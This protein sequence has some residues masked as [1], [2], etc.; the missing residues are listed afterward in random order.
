MADN[1]NMTTSTF[2][3]RAAKA[4]FSGTM[5]LALLAGC[6]PQGQLAGNQILYTAAPADAINV[7]ALALNLKLRLIS[8]TS[9]CAEMV[10]KNN[11][12]LI[13]SDPGGRIFVNGSQ[14][15]PTGGMVCVANTI[16]VPATNEDLIR[17]ALRKTG[18]QI[19]VDV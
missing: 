19:A 4:F 18:R 9:A 8:S 14:V 15:G 17:Q 7:A 13:F 6:Q 3:N 10:D 11:D 5:I 2:M 12:V 16:F 1:Q